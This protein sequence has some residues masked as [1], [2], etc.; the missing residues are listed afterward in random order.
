MVARFV[1]RGPG[2]QLKLEKVDPV[3]ER[4]VISEMR[5]VAFCDNWK[6]ELADGVVLDL[7]RE[8][9]DLGVSGAL[10]E[11]PVLEVDQLLRLAVR[12][13]TVVLDWN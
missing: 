1:E 8:E 5:S 2:I 3:G 11:V 7:Y 6:P 12:V 13:A 10:G 9:A 4:K